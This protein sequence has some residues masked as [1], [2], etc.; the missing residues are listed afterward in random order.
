LSD[1]LISSET[2]SNPAIDADANL[3]KPSWSIDDDA[4][5]LVEGEPLTTAGVLI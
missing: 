2:T 5:A 3:A 1:D 4:F